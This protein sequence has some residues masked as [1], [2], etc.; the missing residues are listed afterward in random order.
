[1]PV[2]VLALVQGNLRREAEDVT[3]PTACDCL[4]RALAALT[5]RPDTFPGLCC[6]CPSHTQVIVWDG[7]RWRWSNQPADIEAVGGEWQA[8]PRV[9]EIHA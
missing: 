4:V 9:E 5:V 6:V 1:M 2:R 8:A 3:P 7:A